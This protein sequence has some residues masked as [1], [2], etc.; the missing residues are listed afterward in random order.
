MENG[1]GQ[2]LK[3]WRKRLGLSQM[4][5]SL[6]SNISSKHISFLETG[7]SKPSREMVHTLANAMGLT[8]G[9]CNLLLRQSEHQV[10]GISSSKTRALRAL[11]IVFFSYLFPRF[12]KF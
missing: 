3:L 9:D 12:M 7:R 5:L 4:G 2:L 8:D 1:F 6:Q 11:K 10:F